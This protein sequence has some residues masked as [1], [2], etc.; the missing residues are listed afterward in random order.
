MVS[1]F[2]IREVENLRDQ[3]EAQ[4]GGYMPDLMV[5][6]NVI[7]FPKHLT[8]SISANST[9][10]VNKNAGEDSYYHYLNIPTYIKAGT[11]AGFLDPY[12]NGRTPNFTGADGINYT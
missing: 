7:L 3:L 8:K 10:E 4:S 11:D 5:P 6:S 12:L 1:E 2:N 9:L